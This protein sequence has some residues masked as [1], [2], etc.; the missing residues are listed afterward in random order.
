MFQAGIKGF[1]GGINAKKYMIITGASKAT[2]TRD[3]PKHLSSIGA[4]KQMGSSRST[5]YE[6]N[7]LLREMK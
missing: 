1:E 6:L 5:R 2:A 3:L 4:F 7:L